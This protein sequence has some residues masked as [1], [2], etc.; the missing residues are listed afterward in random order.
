[1]DGISTDTARASTDFDSRGIRDGIETAVVA[2]TE[3]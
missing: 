3:G 2:E 1:M